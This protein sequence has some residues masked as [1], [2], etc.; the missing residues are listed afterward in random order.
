HSHARTAT[1]V[2]PPA[3]ADG[4]TLG[5][6]AAPPLKGVTGDGR[7]SP[8]AVTQVNAYLYVPSGS[9]A[10]AAVVIVGPL[11]GA[12][13]PVVPPTAL[14]MA[15]PPAAT[16][17]VYVIRCGPLTTRP[18]AAWYH[19]VS[20]MGIRVSPGMTGPMV[21]TPPPSISAR[22]AI[23]LR[24]RVTL[25]DARESWSGVSATG[26]VPVGVIQSA[27]RLK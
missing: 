19:A 2:R 23:W 18:P 21:L 4:A 12:V 16:I 26:G 7:H 22:A 27:I 25:K 24:S 17:P 8:D 15:P 20:S 14:A 5:P 13:L 10:P 11:E 1:R 6:P 9:P 3:A